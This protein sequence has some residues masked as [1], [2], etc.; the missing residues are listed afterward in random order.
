MS[1]SSEKK[2]LSEANKH[3]WPKE[4]HAEIELHRAATNE[5]VERVRCMAAARGSVR[6]SS[7]PEGKNYCERTDSPG[8]QSEVRFGVG[9]ALA[10]LDDPPSRQ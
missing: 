6:V 8:L 5:S 10:E 2:F 3:W 7:L 4:A 1:V 9:S